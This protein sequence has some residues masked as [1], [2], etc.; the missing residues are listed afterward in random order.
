MYKKANTTNQL[1]SLQLMS[2]TERHWCITNCTTH[3][4]E[5][6][7]GGRQLTTKLQ[8][9]NPKPQSWKPQGTNFFDQGLQTQQ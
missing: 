6:D 1:H 7:L 3:P 9:Q 8:D 4:S 2:M 5:V